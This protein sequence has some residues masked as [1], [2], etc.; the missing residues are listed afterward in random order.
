ML[1]G[2]A[3]IAWN[4]LERCLYN[5]TVLS[6][7]TQGNTTL[8]F[9]YIFLRFFYQKYIMMFNY[10]GFFLLLNA[11]ISTNTEAYS[12]WL[13]ITKCFFVTKAPHRQSAADAWFLWFIN[14]KN[15]HRKIS[16]PTI[17][18]LITLYNWD[19]FMFT[20]LPPAFVLIDDYCGWLSELF[21]ATYNK[22]TAARKLATIVN[23][24]INVRCNWHKMK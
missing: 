17:S 23:D 6:A 20:L 24:I 21:I 5:F 4:P 22:L 19:K 9:P 13:L 3:L 7:R 2:V 16:L 1:P 8:Y 18:M 12:M 15:S 10:V 14:D 11:N